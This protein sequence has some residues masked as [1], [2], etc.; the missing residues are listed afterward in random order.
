MC[1]VQAE[2]ASKLPEGRPYLLLVT[3]FDSEGEGRLAT[4]DR[5]P[6]DGVAV[7][8]VDAYD[9]GAP[10]NLQ[11]VQEKFMA[12]YRQT[13]KHLWPWVFVNRM[14][15]SEGANP[16]SNK[17]EF[18]RIKAL[19]L[20]G[21]TGAQEAFLELWRIALRQARATKV[22]G[23]VLDM[24]FYN[25]YRAYSIADVA[26]ERQRPLDEVEKQLHQIGERMARIAGQE[27]PDAKIWI[28]NTGL[29]SSNGL[30]KAEGNQS[31]RS[32]LGRGLLDGS[33]RRHL[34]LVII[35]GGEDILGYCHPSANALREAIQSRLQAYTPVV[36]AYYGTLQLGGTIA[37]WRDAESR[38]DWLREGDCAITDVQKPED[39]SPYLKLLFE[40]YQ[41]VWV[42]AP[43]VGRYD[44]FDPASS[45]RV[46]AVLRQAEASVQ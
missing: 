10:P 19:D 41:F 31:T 44:P 4:F 42:Y 26:R 1:W 40:D 2:E 22:P 7:P 43:T 9:T 6:Y 15:G 14:V 29:S 37:L 16:Q 27:Y 39:F 32:Y 24:E 25:N 46:D 23:M 17:P 3:F 45:E 21:S 20:D 34:G 30:L 33:R 36:R 13:H 11:Q 5:S 8:L 18:Q 38:L 28:L 35:D 12:L